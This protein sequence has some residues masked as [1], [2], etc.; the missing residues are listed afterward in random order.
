[1]GAY[2]PRRAHARP[3][4]V[5]WAGRPRKVLVR[6]AGGGPTGA[7]AYSDVNGSLVVVFDTP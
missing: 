6:W 7:G 4:L 3:A 1:M 5:A 2:D